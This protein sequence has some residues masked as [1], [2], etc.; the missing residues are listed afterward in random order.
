MDS[1][2]IRVERRELHDRREPRSS[3]EDLNQ[4]LREKIEQIDN[5]RRQHLRR[6]TDR[7]NY[8]STA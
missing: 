7:P 3:I 6:A 4:R 8:S 1:R 5:D 2:H